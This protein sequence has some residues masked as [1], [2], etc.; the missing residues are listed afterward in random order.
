MKCSPA[1][2]C[3]DHGLAG[4]G[5]SEGGGAVRAADRGGGRLGGPPRHADAAQLHRQRRPG[6]QQRQRVLLLAF[7]SHACCCDVFASLLGSVSGFAS[8]SSSGA[9]IAK[10][11]NCMSVFFVVF[12]FFSFLKVCFL[13][14]LEREI[15]KREREE[16]MWI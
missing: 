8:F 6:N 12:H 11:C 5:D 7:H 4:C 1:L 13:L 3:M 2:T 16:K 9:C 10:R 14:T 15:E